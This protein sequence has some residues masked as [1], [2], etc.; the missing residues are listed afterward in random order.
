VIS[1]FANAA[2]LLTQPMSMK[3]RHALEAGALQTA[4]ISHYFADRVTHL[5]HRTQHKESPR[6]GSRTVGKNK[7]HYTD[8]YL[9]NT[10]DGLTSRV[11]EIIAAMKSN[12]G[13]V[14]QWAKE[15][16]DAIGIETISI[17]LGVKDD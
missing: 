2:K 7:M 11:T 5:S 14:K 3:S 6:A 15:L 13:N 16:E 17:R 10:I 12:N 9:L 4:L 8:N 1:Q